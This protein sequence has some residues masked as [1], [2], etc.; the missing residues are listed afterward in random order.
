MPE[1]WR[2]FPKAIRLGR[3]TTEDIGPDRLAFYRRLVGDIYR[4][5]VTVE[6]SQTIY[7]SMSQ[8][9]TSARQVFDRLIADVPRSMGPD[10]GIAVLVDVT[11]SPPELI[12]EPVAAHVGEAIGTLLLTDPGR[13]VVVMMPALRTRLQRSFRRVVGADRQA[14]MT[15]QYD[16]GSRVR[17]SADQAE[18]QPIHPSDA[19]YTKQLQRLNQPIEDRLGGKILR[20]LGHFQFGT[21]TEH[22]TRYFF[23]ASYAVQ[24]VSQLTKDLVLEEK[25]SSTAPL[26]IM[27]HQT[28][29]PWLTEVATEVAQRLGIPHF[30]LPTEGDVENVPNSGDA[31]LLLDVVN[32][33]NTTKALI[34]RV[35]QRGLNVRQTILAVF[36]DRERLGT[37]QNSYKMVAENSTYWIRSIANPIERL[38]RKRVRCEQCILGIEPTDPRS[39]QPGIRSFDMWEILLAHKWVPERYGPGDSDN[40]QPGPRRF[41]L[42]PDFVRIFKEYGDWIAFKLDEML[43][44]MRTGGAG[45]EEAVY[46]CPAEPA[47]DTLTDL[48]RARHG[49]RPVPVKIPRPILRD[50]ERGDFSTLEQERDVGWGGQ[51]SDLA[52]SNS[53]SV[54]LIDEFNGSNT[55]ALS[56]LKVLQRFDITATAYLPVINLNPGSALRLPSGLEVP[57][58]P[59][60]EIPAP[61]ALGPA[62]LDETGNR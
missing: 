40:T 24:E 37:G 23:D 35:R 4:G 53:Y 27:S 55:T 17:V 48:L 62:P 7:L 2:V 28:H 60:Y 38:K 57:V 41:S 30:G 19:D 56:M 16:N 59:L 54:V 32:T 44:T 6:P 3:A 61:R 58:C 1:R 34:K 46:V 14:H 33:G 12:S 43:T 45:V 39:S 47:M 15:I 52:K 18:D 36:V 9:R 10:E 49:A 11:E 8:L 22:C 26:V 25:R 51:L 42:V 50:A 20:R 5:D 29:S 31:L 21:S 13:Q